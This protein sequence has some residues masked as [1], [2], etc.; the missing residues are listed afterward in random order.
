MQPFAPP[1]YRNPLP[2]PGEGSIIPAQPHDLALGHVWTAIPGGFFAL[3]PSVAEG[4]I[5]SNRPFRHRREM[6]ERTGW[7]FRGGRLT[8]FETG[9][10]A[11]IF[12]NSYRR[13]RKERDRPALLEIGVNP[14]LRIPPFGE[15]EELGVVSVVIRHHDDFGGRTRGRFREYAHLHG[16][17]LFVDDRPLL[18]RGAVRPP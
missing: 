5:I 8:H 6:T 13:A 7:T 9:V 17:N 1:L 14:N 10:G 18:T 4:R 3:D 15:E 16:A 12:A 11:E 2:E